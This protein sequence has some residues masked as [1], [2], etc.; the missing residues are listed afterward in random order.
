MLL[1]ALR[2]AVIE[3]D[4]F[5]G[6]RLIDVAGNFPQPIQRSRYPEYKTS[7]RLTDAVE[8]GVFVFISGETLPGDAVREVTQHSM[9]VMVE[10]QSFSLEVGEASGPLTF[11]GTIE[12]VVKPRSRTCL[13]YSRVSREVF[14]S[15]SPMSSPGVEAVPAP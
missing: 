13:A 14:R 5:F 7:S 12:A 1:D 2:D 3:V 6:R 4:G 10:M 9:D 8:P 11:R 15:K